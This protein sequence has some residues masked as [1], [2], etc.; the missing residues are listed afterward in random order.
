MVSTNL[1]IIL[2]FARLCILASLALTPA[3]ASTPSLY[4][5]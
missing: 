4:W 5:L 2:T 1:S 3:A